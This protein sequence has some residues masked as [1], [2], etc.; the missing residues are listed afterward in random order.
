MQMVQK[1]LTY[2]QD[3]T[4]KPSLTAQSPKQDVSLQTNHSHPRL[5]TNGHCIRQLKRYHAVSEAQRRQVGLHGSVLTHEELSESAT[6]SWND[7]ACVAVL[8][9]PL[10]A[11]PLLCARRIALV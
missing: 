5:L 10:A 9:T 4:S 1:V 3:R 2:L 8:A 11:L 7:T 6:G